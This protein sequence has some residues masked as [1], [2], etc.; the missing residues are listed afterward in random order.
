MALLAI[1]R[2]VKRSVIGVGGLV[3]IGGMAS[4]AGIGSVGIVALV[5]CVAIVFDGCVCAIQYIE[6]IVYG[7]SGGCPTGF[8]GV[9]GCAVGRYSEF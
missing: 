8:S 7:K 2:K 5:T 6:V 9:A 1:L 3:V 4:G